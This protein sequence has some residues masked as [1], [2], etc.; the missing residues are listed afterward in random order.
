MRFVR[1]IAST[2]CLLVG[3]LVGGRGVSAQSSPGDGLYYLVANTRPPDAYL[4]LRTHPSSAQGERIAELPNGT[5]LQVLQRQ[6]D[7]WWYV[8]VVATGQTGWALSR[9]GNTTWIICCAPPSPPLL[10]A[11][12]R[13]KP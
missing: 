5:R 8:R 9:G 6:S 11:P 7:D 3:L 1:R 4:A 12:V 10:E 13:M 2:F